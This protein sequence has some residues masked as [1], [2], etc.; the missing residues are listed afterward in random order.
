MIGLLFIL[1]FTIDDIVIDSTD[2][3]AIRE[4]GAHYKKLGNYPE[5]I[6]WLKKGLKIAPR[7][8]GLLFELG[9]SYYLNHDYENAEAIFTRLIDCAHTVDA[10][11][12]LGAVLIKQRRYNDAVKVFKSALELKTD[13]DILFHL[14]GVY[15]VMGE[16]RLA[17]D[18]YKKIIEHTPDDPR[19]YEGR[20]S[21]YWKLGE[22]ELSN[23]DIKRA[24]ELRS[25]T[26]FGE[27]V[28]H[29]VVSSP[30]KEKKKEEEES[31]GIYSRDPEILFYV[32]EIHQITGEWEL[33]VKTY[34]A[35]IKL[36]PKNPKYYKE[37][38]RCYKELGKFE[39]SEADLQKVKELQK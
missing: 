37:R 10:Y 8:T 34:T 21:A 29:K 30:H 39:Q 23:N 5:S 28:P 11:F 12:N 6:K 32:G 27:V 35:A 17:I 15:L 22:N 36:D 19:A 13:V 31:P 24:K 4:R 18:V 7:D 26:Y 1:V 38:A 2:I 20:A 14:A 9:E 25:K 3:V 16:Y 33:A